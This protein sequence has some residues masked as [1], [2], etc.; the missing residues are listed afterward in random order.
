M[1]AEKLGGLA[2]VCFSVE[3]TKNQAWIRKKQVARESR[4]LN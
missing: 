3:R 1:K 4:F 2:F